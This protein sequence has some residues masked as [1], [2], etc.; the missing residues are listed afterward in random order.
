MFLD[1]VI[2]TDS[3]IW[4]FKKVFK[5]LVGAI[6]IG[7]PLLGFYTAY[8]NLLERNDIKTTIRFAISSIIILIIIYPAIGFF[9]YYFYNFDILHWLLS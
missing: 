3:I 9:L 4:L 2:D 7:I 1:I 5:Y 8:I 6:L